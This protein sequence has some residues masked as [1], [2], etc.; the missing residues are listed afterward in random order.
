[1]DV[2]GGPSAEVFLAFID[3][4]LAPVRR[5]GDVVVLDN[6]GAHQSGA[7]RRAFQRQAVKVRDLPPCSPDLDP[8]EMCFSEVKAF[9]RATRA[10][11]RATLDQA[12]VDAINAVTPMDCAGWFSA[13]GYSVSI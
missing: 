6:L 13:S 10:R 1:M 5:P 3:Q 8:I 4:V 7:V 9:L 12:I 2:N 11:C